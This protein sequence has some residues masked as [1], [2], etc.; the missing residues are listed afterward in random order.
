[1]SGIVDRGE[2]ATCEGD[3]KTLSVAAESYF[4]QAGG[5]S[6]PATGVDDDRFERTLMN[7][8]LLREPSGLYDMNADGEVVLVATSRCQTI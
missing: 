7:Q 6:I 3:A 2:N 1:M 8:G 5:S 4:A